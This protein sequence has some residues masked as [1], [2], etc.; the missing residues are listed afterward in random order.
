[1]VEAAAVL[2]LVNGGLAVAGATAA[3]LVYRLISLGA[4]ALVGWL[5]VLAQRRRLVPAR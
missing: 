4:V 5:V 3:V 1:V 2:V